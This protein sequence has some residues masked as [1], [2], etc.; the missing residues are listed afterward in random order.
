LG[1]IT[2]VVAF[3]LDPDVVKADEIM[4]TP[5]PEGHSST[6][7]QSGVYPEF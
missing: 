5:V 1:I 2:R 4:Y 3:N 7:R 6:S